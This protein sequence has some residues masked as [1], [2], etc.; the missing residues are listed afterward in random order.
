LALKPHFTTNNEAGMPWQLTGI[1]IPSINE[2]PVSNVQ[3]TLINQ[4]T[5][6]AYISWECTPSAGFLY[7]TVKRDGVQLSTVSVTE[8]NDLLPT[9]G[10]YEYCIEAVYSTG[11]TTP[12]CA[13]VEWPSPSLTWTPDSLTATVWPGTS[14]YRALSIGNTGTGTLSFEFPDYVDH[15]GD[16]PMAYC[17]ASATGQDEYIGRVQLN[18]LD[19][20][21]GWEGYSDYT[22]LSAQLIKGVSSPI[23]V[24]NG[25]N[26]Y[27]QDKLY[28]WI[29]YDHNTIFDANELTQ[30]ASQGGGYAFSGTIAVPPTALTGFTTMR[31]RMS[32]STAADPCGTQ[33]YGEVEDYTVKIQE[34]TFAVSVVPASGI[35]QANEHSIINVEFSAAGEYAVEGI[36]Y[37]TLKLNSNDLNHSSVDIPL[38]MIVGMPGMIKGVVTDCVTGEPI[39]GVFVSVGFY[40]TMTDATGAYTLYV[41]AGTY[42]V[43]FS[44]VGYQTINTLGNVSGSGVT[45][46]NP[47]MCEF[48]YPPDCAYASVNF[49]DTQCTVSWCPPASV[50]EMIFDDGTAENYTAWQFAGNKYAVKFTPQGYPAKISGAKF[51]IGDGPY[52][53]TVGTPFQVL[54]CKADAEG[55]PGETIDSVPAMVNNLGWMTVNGLNATI[56]SGDFFIVMEQGS[57]SPNC[58]YLGVDETLPLVNRSYSRNEINGEEWQLSAYQDFIIRPIVSCPDTSGYNYFQFSRFYLGPVNPVPPALGTATL[59]S[60]SLTSTSWIDDGS[61]WANMLPSGWYTYGIKAIYPNGEWSEFTFTNYVQH[62]MLADLTINAQLECGSIPAAGAIVKLSGIYYPYYSIT[63]TVPASGTLTFSQIIR[64]DLTVSVTYPGYETYTQTLTL[65]TNKIINVDLAQSLNSP[66]NMAVDEANLVASWEEPRVTLMSQDFESG[67]FPPPGWQNSTQGIMGWY[68][69]NNGSSANFVIPQHTKYAVVNDEL[70]VATNNGCCDSLITP[71]IDLRAAP[72]YEL[73]FSSYYT[74]FNGQLANVVMSTDGGATWTSIYTVQPSV[75][76]QNIKIDLSAYSGPGGLAA[77]KFAFHADDSGNQAS[78]WAVDDVMVSCGGAAVSGYKVYLDGVEV[79]QTTATSWNFDPASITCTPLNEAGVAATYCTGDSEPATDLFQ[80]L[81]PYPP[82]NLVADTSITATTG[83][84]ILSWE[85]PQCIGPWVVGYNVYRNDSVIASYQN[86]NTYTDLN[87]APGSYCYNIT[88]IYD[89]T[90]YGFPG[91]FAESIKAGPACINMVYGLD[92]PVFEDFSSG[93]FDTTLWNPGD[94]WLVDEDSDNPVPAAKFRWDPVLN[95]YSSSLEST[96][97]NATDISISLPYKIYLDYDVKLEDNTASGTE[98]L[99]VEI[100]NGIS[101]NGVKEYTNS[102][103]FDWTA[104]HLDITEF[105]D[106]NVFKVRFRANGVMSGEILYW[107]VDNVHIYIQIVGSGMINLVTQLVSS[108]DN[109]IQLMWTPPYGGG[110]F[111][112]YILD[113]NTAES[114]VSF[115]SPGEYWIGNEFPVMDE[116]VLKTASVFMEAG[117]SGNYSIDVFD[118]D[119]NL[120]G[121]SASIEPAFGGWTDVALDDIPFNGTFYLMLHMQVSA[122]S[123]VLALDT[124][125]PN[126]AGDYEWFYNGSGWSKLSVSG[127]GPCVALIR[128]L[129]YVD[130]K[131]SAITFNNGSAGSGYVSPM[132]DGLVKNSLNINTGNE[133]A[134]VTASG[135]NTDSLIGY[136]VYRRAYAVFPAG[137][138]SPASGDWTKIATVSATQYL[139]S[140]LSN[141]V[142]NCYEYEVTMQYSEGESLPSNIDW[143]CIFTDI[144]PAATGEVRIYP[145]PATTFIRI[146]LNRLIDIITVYNALGAVITQKNVKGETSVMLNTTGFA[147]GAYSVK[148][149]TAG[150]E[151]FSRKFVKL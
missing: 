1:K 80:N 92:L 144:N 26:A 97:I 4:L 69:A 106:S 128:V 68:S 58:A 134:H 105:A 133:I 115:N 129:G 20:A 52:G 98:N 44:K 14:V 40:N 46:I 8:Y 76:W 130:G 125:G 88:A 36:Y 135:D 107:A 64:G 22:S 9:Y 2:V 15:L 25:G 123:D 138:N 6:E 62:K 85:P 23:T 63:D 67:N 30:L 99:T 143:E 84:A 57:P 91:S 82:L 87:L 104:E 19:K 45:T 53:V 31:V 146:D 89:L 48:P 60:N 96:C 136:N 74:G 10:I 132:S 39:D 29:D 93:E 94:N 71:A 42:Y 35:M 86:V 120:A 90:P 142:T 3:S 149:A 101:W 150:G 131:K 13:S 59:L 49:E 70:G 79:G 121:S 38:K 32:Y 122:Q 47:Q 17:T 75:I 41:D 118:A 124:N 72:D 11:G 21:S 151:S 7:F 83:V 145:N 12:A 127:F 114:G 116:G 78:G 81:Y 55:L 103:S 109:D 18:S 113:D 126:A 112:S 24:T 5:G 108:T 51:M 73:S 66:L 37:S 139:D 147:A 33:S 117:G 43:V 102:G 95:N 27:S 110:T 61:V 137:P 34:P 50:Q 140:G 100:W 111:M 119:H 28:V 54:V 148:F 65:D 141:M 56:T 77:V 16:S